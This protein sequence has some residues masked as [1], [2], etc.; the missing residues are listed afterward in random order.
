MEPDYT[1]K[2]I[3]SETKYDGVI[4]KIRLDEAQ[5]SNGAIVKR[6]LSEHPG[7]V[8]VLAV[9][10]SNNCRLVRQFR[11]AVGKTWLEIPAGKLEPGEDHLEC[12]KRELSEETGC[13]ATEY[14]DLGKYILSP[15]YSTELLHI[16][17]ARGL[18]SG[19]AH[20]DENELLNAVTVPYDELHNQALNNEIEDIKTAM[21]VLRARVYIK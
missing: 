9:D 19:E 16:Y 11:Y 2:T 5:L 17:L 8:G 3:S 1:E 20:P 6:E 21:A 12:A 4:V 10:E 13:T 14:I 15:G 18:S 7:G